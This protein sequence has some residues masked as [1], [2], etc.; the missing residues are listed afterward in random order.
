MTTYRRDNYQEL[1]KRTLRFSDCFYDSTLPPEAIEAVA[2]NLTV[3]K[4]PTVLRQI[5]GKFWGWEGSGDSEGSC[6]G[7][8]THVWNYAQAIPHLFH[9]LERSLR[10]TEFGPSQ[11]E[12]GRQVFRRALPIRPSIPGEADAADGQFG[13]I[14]KVYREW[15]ISGDDAWLRAIWPCQDRQRR[16]RASQLCLLQHVHPP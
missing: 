6:P 11:D 13:G 1:R 10:E 15:R 12:E 5:D 14:I 4:S 7:S 16:K 8:C 9:E 2:A 3:L